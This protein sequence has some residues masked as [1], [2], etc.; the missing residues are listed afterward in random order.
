MGKGGIGMNVQDQYIINLIQK[1]H[2]IDG[3]G[4]E[5]FRKVTLEKNPIGQAE[6]SALVQ[7][8]NTKVV[9]GVKMG[10]G[11]PFPDT[12]KEGILICNAELS[13]LAS[14]NFE[15]GPPGEESIELARII[16][17]GIRESKAIDVEKLCITE[18][19]KV[20]MVFV[21]IYPINHQ[22]NLID[23]SGLAAA[24]ALAN[25][26]MPK[27]EGDKLIYD[28]KKTPLPLKELPIPVTFAQIK[29][30]LVVDPSL[31]EER[32]MNGRI[33]VSTKE[34]GN[35]CAIQKGGDA[36]TMANIE[37]ALDM[38]VKKGKDL[39]KLV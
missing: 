14:P 9:V 29:D 30:H 6:G 19:E 8:G 24:S 34:N 4:L 2:R 31:E 16:D 5:D 26:K 12:P 39:R 28:E 37:K 3:R 32:A 1:A 36:M 21:D 17:R 33:T 10:V 13:P 11:T 15:L 35:V 20:W 38:S 18:G 25:A 7:I 22:G 27:L 23:A